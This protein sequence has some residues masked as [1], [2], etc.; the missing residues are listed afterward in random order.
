M[1]RSTLFTVARSPICNR[2]RCQVEL[3]NHPLMAYGELRSWP[4]VW[5]QNTRGGVKTLTGEIGV[6]TY[7]Y[8]RHRPATKCFLVIDHQNETFVGTLLFDDQ[9]FGVKV[10]DLLR[11]LV[12]RP[13][14][15][16]GDLD[17]SNV[18]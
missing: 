4:P 6:L 5:T 18:L 3:R 9:A 17:V 1:Y 2:A 16:I 12:G 8:M 7:V 14:K 11:G 13:V 15:D 10:C